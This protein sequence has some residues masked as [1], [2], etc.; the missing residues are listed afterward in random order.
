MLCLEQTGAPTLA[1]QGI[2]H[3]AYFTPSF[4]CIWYEVYVIVEFY[5]LINYL[6]NYESLTRKANKSKLG[7]QRVYQAA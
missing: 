6:P 2:C 3:T 5:Y 7:L 4:S 1:V